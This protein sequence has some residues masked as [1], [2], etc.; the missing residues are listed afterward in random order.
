MTTWDD[1]TAAKKAMFEA[2]DT[3]IAPRGQEQ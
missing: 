2:T 3:D 1:Y